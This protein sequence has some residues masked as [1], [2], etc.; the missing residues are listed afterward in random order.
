ME[1]EVAT[2]ELAE[3]VASVVRE[4]IAE[5]IAAG[6]EELRAIIEANKRGLD[7]ETEA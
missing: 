4:V 2:P 1:P 3:L 5:M 6:D 7:G